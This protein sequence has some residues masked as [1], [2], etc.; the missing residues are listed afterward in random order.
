MK[1]SYTLFL[2]LLLTV[3]GQAIGQTKMV[4]HRSHSGSIETFDAA[5]EGN[6]GNPPNQQEFQVLRKVVR[7]SDSSAIEVYDLHQDTMYNHH[8]WNN[9]KIRLD[10]LQKMFPDISFEGF[11]DPKTT[12]QTRKHGAASRYSF[13]RIES[14]K[15]DSRR[16]PALAL[17]SSA[18][19]L[20][21]AAGAVSSRR[22]GRK[23]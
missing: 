18:A 9:P 4:A 16:I 2:T 11:E 21:V 1:A 13:A 17:V 8:F 5:G 10:S 20:L 14:T 7:I 22:K 12:S 6:F 23:S 19:A 3:A 15:A